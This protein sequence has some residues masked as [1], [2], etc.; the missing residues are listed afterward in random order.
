[1]ASENQKL[2][3]ALLNRREVERC[4]V[5]LTESEQKVLAV[6]LETPIRRRAFIR[7]AAGTVLALLAGASVPVWLVEQT[8]PAQAQMSKGHNADRPRDDRH[9]VIVANR[10]AGYMTLDVAEKGRAVRL[11]VMSCH[12]KG[13]ITLKKTWSNFQT[14]L[15]GAVHQLKQ[16]PA[17]NKSNREKVVDSKKLYASV[18]GED[19]HTE[20]VIAQN[21]CS[22][23]PYIELRV[24]PDHPTHRNKVDDGNF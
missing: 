1:M 8:Q 10:E 4:G 24:L 11:M 21:W 18:K 17:P 3:D 23:G 14:S 13:A 6:I 15:L 9:F 20:I 12:G 16:A 7:R 2:R 5:L 19:G 22:D